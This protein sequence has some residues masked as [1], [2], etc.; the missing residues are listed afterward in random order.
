[1][2]VNDE[3]I[4]AALKDSHE[5]L[6]RL[7][8]RMRDK[9]P[10]LDPIAGYYAHMGRKY[11]NRLGALKD[12]REMQVHRYF[13]HADRDGAQVIM[14]S[15]G[16]EIPGDLREMTNDEFRAADGHIPYEDES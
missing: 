14:C 15:C 4:D 16:G 10:T 9:D 1:M 6:R 8:R 12:D 3:E 5:R 11:N 13:S 2:R 7:E